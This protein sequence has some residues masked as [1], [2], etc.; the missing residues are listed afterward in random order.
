MH[1]EEVEA[2]NLPGDS[3]DTV[4]PIGDH[5]NPKRVQCRYALIGIIAV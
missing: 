2:S 4:K 3:A 1:P 5:M